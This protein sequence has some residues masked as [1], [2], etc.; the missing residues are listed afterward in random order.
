VNAA[1]SIVAQNGDL[2][3]F[4]GRASLSGRG[5]LKGRVQYR[6]R[7]PAQPLSVRSLELLAITCSSDRRQASIFGDGEINGS[8]R[9]PFRIDVQ[10]L[11]KPGKGADTYRILLQG[12]Y[13]SGQSTLRRGTVQIR[14][15]G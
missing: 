3:T 14:P 10:D 12:G 4:G 15:T 5:R 6:D 1:G 13:D 11:S 2:A 7:G 8:G 9:F